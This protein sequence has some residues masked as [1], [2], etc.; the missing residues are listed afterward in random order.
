M[1]SLRINLIFKSIF[2]QIPFFGGEIKL[3]GG[4]IKLK[5]WISLYFQPIYTKFKTGVSCYYGAAN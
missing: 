1:G 5:I 3:S 2:L 4:E